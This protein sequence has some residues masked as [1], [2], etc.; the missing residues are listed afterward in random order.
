[1]QTFLSFR[2]AAGIAAALLLVA[3][4]AQSVAPSIPPAPGSA[5][6]ASANVT[7]AAKNAPL[8]Y[9]TD[10]FGYYSVFGYPQ[11]GNGDLAPTFDLSGSATK[12]FE[13]EGFGIS[14][15][16]AI[17]VSDSN[18]YVTVYPPGAS[19]NTA[20]SGVITCGGPDNQP[21]VP[22]ALTYD[23]GGTLYVHYVL[24]YHGEDN[25]IETYPPGQQNGCVSD[26]NDIYGDQI[27]EFGGIAVDRDIVYQANANAIIGFK[28]TD[29]GNVPPD[30]RIAGART[31]LSV[32]NDLAFDGKGRMY[33]SEYSDVRVF[34]RNAHGNAK[35]IAVIAGPDTQIPTTDGIVLSIAV[36][37]QGTIFLG[38][39][40]DGMGSILVFPPGSSG[41]A[42]PS[43]VIT[44][45]STN[46]DESFFLGVK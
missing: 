22:Q 20:P 15:K 27:S 12:L 4:S 21:A 41:D 42:A 14:N 5:A 13:P 16:G 30:V 45:P 37:K 6:S 8:I 24:G 11:S 7:R 32:A 38:I 33:V 25:A 46:L 23:T 40:Q 26:T 39:E 44:G 36:A 9:A 34:A 2:T 28:V 3:C 19:G 35:P 10:E 43:A 18:N 17:A 1:M 31:G 29:N